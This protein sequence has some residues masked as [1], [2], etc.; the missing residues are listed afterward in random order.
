V[1]DWWLDVANEDGFLCTDHT[2]EQAAWKQVTAAQTHTLQ[3][4]R[5]TEHTFQARLTNAKAARWT[6]SGSPLGMVSFGGTSPAFIYVDSA[7]QDGADCIFHFHS[8][9]Y[10][11]SGGDKGI[12]TG[13]AFAQNFAQTENM[14]RAFTPMVRGEIN[15]ISIVQGQGA[16][17]PLGFTVYA[18][19]NHMKVTVVFDREVE[20][21]DDMESDELFPLR[22][23]GNYVP[24]SVSC[25][26]PAK[27]YGQGGAIGRIWEITYTGSP[28]NTGD[29]WDLVDRPLFGDVGALP[30]TGTVGNLY[31]P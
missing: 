26:D 6:Y 4:E 17:P 23:G 27:H 9:D 19:A 13:N 16:P 1:G 24:Q 22:A 8:T 25:V 2:T 20:D 18:N 28:V 11:C 31:A 29:T 15:V 10:Y 5:L 12:Q 14:R 21:A 30:K 3:I 7:T